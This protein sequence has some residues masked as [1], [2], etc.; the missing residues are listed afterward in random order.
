MNSIFRSLEKK[1]G[2]EGHLQKYQVFL[3]EVQARKQAD[4]AARRAQATKVAEEAKR[5]E[6]EKRRREQQMLQ[7]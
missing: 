1:E 6:L 2:L 3:R 4:E 7:V 5:T